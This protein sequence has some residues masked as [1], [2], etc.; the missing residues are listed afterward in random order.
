MTLAKS[1]IVPL[2]S[3]SDYSIHENDQD[4]VPL[5]FNQVLDSPLEIRRNWHKL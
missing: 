5:I 4:Y 1:E 2:N 3:R